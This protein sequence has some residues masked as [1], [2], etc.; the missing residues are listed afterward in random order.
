MDRCAI[1]GFIEWIEKNVVNAK[2]ER[3]LQSQA[4][5]SVGGVI[6]HL[7]LAE[8]ATLAVDHRA[9]RS[10]ADRQAPTTLKTST[11][12]RRDL[13]DWPRSRPHGRYAR[14]FF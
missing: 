13:K 8:L 1:A 12:G 10:A 5:S 3:L 11:L 7:D 6:S 2:P 9:A 14:P 4:F